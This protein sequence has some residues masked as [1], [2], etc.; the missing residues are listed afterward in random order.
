M[1]RKCPATGKSA[2]AGQRD[3]IRHALAFAPRKSAVA[4]AY[5][6]YLC[7]HCNYWHTTKRRPYT[8]AIERTK[9][10]DRKRNRHD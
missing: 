10:L 9:R 3:A 1:Q 2:F 8:D 6:A 7:P 4:L 5:R